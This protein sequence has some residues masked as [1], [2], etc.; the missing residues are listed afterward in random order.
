[1]RFVV[2]VSLLFAIV[3]FANA[4]ISYMNQPEK[5]PKEVLR[6]INAER[7]R[8]KNAQSSKVSIQSVEGESN[9]GNGNG[10]DDREPAKIKFVNPDKEASDLCEEFITGL[11]HLNFTRMLNTVYNSSTFDYDNHHV[12]ADW[13]TGAM[14]RDAN[15]RYA[16]GGFRFIGIDQFVASIDAIGVLLDH[17]CALSKVSIAVRESTLSNRNKPYRNEE[18]RMCDVRFYIGGFVKEQFNFPGFDKVSFENGHYHMELTRNAA[19]KLKIHRIVA[20][21]LEGTVPESFW[22]ALYGETNIK[23]RCKALNDLVE[24][25]KPL[26]TDFIEYASGSS[27][28]E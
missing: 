16:P 13:N 6:A 8:M 10:N 18:T 20:N 26:F 1:M 11:I 7:Q 17:Q 9:N 24:P 15:G 25:K 3:A 2:L 12:K 21:D 23:K 14:V 27:I 22:S 28:S 4:R 19:G 5:Y